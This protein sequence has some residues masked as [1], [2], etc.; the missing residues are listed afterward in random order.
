MS[1]DKIG[2]Q[3][4]EAEYKEVMKELAR[5]IDTFLNG[6]SGQKKN[7]FI[8]MCFKTGQIVGGRMNYLSNCR[9]ADV[10]TALKEQVAY[11]EGTREAEDSSTKH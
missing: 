8:L 10:I 2:T 6:D 9:R 3:P 7:G 4:I 11:F 1:D 5:A